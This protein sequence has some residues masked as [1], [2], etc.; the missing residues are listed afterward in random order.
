VPSVFLDKYT[1]SN[2]KTKGGNN[3]PYI[4]QDHSATADDNPMSQISFG[5]S[6]DASS[7]WTEIEY[8]K[9]NLQPPTYDEYFGND[10]NDIMSDIKA[11][12]IA[13][14]AA[15]THTVL[16]TADNPKMTVLNAASTSAK[17]SVNS[18]GVLI[19]DG[20]GK[21]EVNKNGKPEDYESVSFTGTGFYAGL[22]ILRNCSQ[23][24]TGGNVSIYGAVLVDAKT[25]DGEDCG[26]DYEPF[27]A[28]GHP[29]IK[30]SLEALNN[31]GVGT[32]GGMIGD[33]LDWYEVIEG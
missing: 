13:E 33:N 24:D 15:G 2:L 3:Y 14:I 5:G 7:V 21:P 30:Y 6:K 23:L 9:N 4:G 17:L 29:D 25:A 27:S 22:I 11:R 12:E 20:S 31:A 19:V 8:I 26:P 32:S 16:G 10:L 18:A 28:G 1:G